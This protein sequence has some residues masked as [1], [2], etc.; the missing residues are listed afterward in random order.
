MQKTGF[1]LQILRPASLEDLQSR[2]PDH[3]NQQ[4]GNAVTMQANASLL[5]LPPTTNNDDCQTFVA[6]LG[7]AKGSDLTIDASQSTQL[8]ARFAQLLVLA[9]RRWEMDS[10]NFRIVDPSEKFASAL[11][12]LGLHTILLAKGDVE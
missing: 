7:A 9:A 8:T 12:R 10:L 1:G 2:A 4:D 6:A 5:S 11:Q 3:A